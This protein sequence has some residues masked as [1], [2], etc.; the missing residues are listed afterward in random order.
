MRT[1]R[2]AGFKTEPASSGYL[3]SIPNRPGAPTRRNRN[4]MSRRG[5]FA[6]LAILAGGACSGGSDV[7]AP[8]AS[9]NDQVTVGNNFFSP[10]TLTVPVGT[11]V[12]WVWNPGGTDHNVTFA[13]GAHSPTQASGT[14]PRTFTA[15]GTYAFHCTIHG[16]ALMS[17]TITVGSGPA[18]GGAGDG[19]TGGGGGSGG[20]EYGG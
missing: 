5:L 6:S 3:S 19:G 9:G 12:T 2:L 11:T 15:A 1:S 18:G 17:G 10:T 8:T 7:T 4:A 14:W 20:G 13:D 16:A